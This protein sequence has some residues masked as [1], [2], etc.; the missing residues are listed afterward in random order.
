MIFNGSLVRKFPQLLCEGVASRARDAESL[1]SANTALAT[2][3]Q[4]GEGDVETDNQ[5]FP[6]NHQRESKGTCTL[7][8][9]SLCGREPER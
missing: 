2:N 7:L 5:Y 4:H 8:F 1:Q 6:F 3:F 9:T